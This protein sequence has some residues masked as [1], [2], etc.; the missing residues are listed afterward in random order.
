[1]LVLAVLGGIALVLALIS[2]SMQPDRRRLPAPTL[3][4]E[5]RLLALVE[6]LEAT[7][8]RR[9]AAC[10]LDY[11]AEHGRPHPRTS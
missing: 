11:C 7:D 5:P 1:M 6:R 8:R 10:S 3:D 9:E 2:A 4:H